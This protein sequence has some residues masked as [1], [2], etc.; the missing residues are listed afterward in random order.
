MRLLLFLRQGQLS[1]AAES[2][3]FQGSTRVRAPLNEVF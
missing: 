3:V 2:T 1:A